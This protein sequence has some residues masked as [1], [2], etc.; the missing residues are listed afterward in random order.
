VIQ[1]E[2]GA[3]QA[4]PRTH[5]AAFHTSFFRVVN[6]SDEVGSSCTSMLLRVLASPFP[7][8]H[9]LV[10][11]CPVNQ[12]SGCECYL[13]CPLEL[14]WIFRLASH[15]LHARIDCPIDLASTNLD[16][17]STYQEYCCSK[18]NE[19]PYQEGSLGGPSSP[20]NSCHA[21]AVCLTFQACTYMVDNTLKPSAGNS[22]LPCSNCSSHLSGDVVLQV[23]LS[24]IIT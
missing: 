12:T 6:G 4:K 20:R 1:G 7:P 14:T 23:N 24:D 2:T 8:V 5:E 11:K 3:G 22:W 21:L 10:G 9:R 15:L 13:P 19:S 18:G 17:D 16:A